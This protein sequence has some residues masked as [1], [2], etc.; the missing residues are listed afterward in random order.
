[1]STPKKSPT[2]AEVRGAARRVGL[3]VVRLQFADGKPTGEYWLLD[4]H[5]RCVHGSGHHV[6][7][8]GESVIRYCERL[9]GAT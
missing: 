5:Y 8:S 1:M 7:L 9:G 2:Y 3:R 4:K 6:G